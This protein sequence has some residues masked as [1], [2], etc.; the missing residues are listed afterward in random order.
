MT[1]SEQKNELISWI[2]ALNNESA[3][4]QIMELRN[5]MVEESV[6]NQIWDTLSNEEKASI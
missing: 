6:E 4:N 3:V 2:Q 1:I 5:K